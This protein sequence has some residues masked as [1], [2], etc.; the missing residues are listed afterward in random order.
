MSLLSAEL[1]RLWARRA[2]AVVLLVTVVLAGLLAGSALW[3]TRPATADELAAARSQLQAQAQLVE[4]DYAACVSAPEGFFGPDATAETCEQVRLTVEDLLPR[5]ELDLADQLDTR[6]FGLVFLVVG[7]AVV[8]GATFAG[9]DWSSGA[10]S[11]QLL[12]EPR[13]LRTWT[14]KATAVALSTTLAAAVITAAFW[15]TLYAAAAARGTGVPDGTTVAVLEQSARGLALV[16][17]AALGSHA[18]TMLLRSTVGTL[19]LLFAYAVAGEIVVASLPFEQ[20]S[21]WSL[22]N[23]VQAWVT[24]GMLVYDESLCSD[25][26]AESGCTPTYVLSGAHGAAYLGVLLLVV[27][28]ASPLS[29]GRRDVS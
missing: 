28:V 19:G 29:F 6:G 26:L 22:A 8:L 17:A 24:D 15:T 14:A 27:L 25:V 23:N 12:H 7:A 5:A 13:R 20:M 9:A 2:V 18:L 4:Q 16:A 3:S 21:R 11:T 10:L 1:R